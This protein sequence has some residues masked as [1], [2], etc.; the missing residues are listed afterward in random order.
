MVWTGVSLHHK[1]YIVFIN[2]NFTTAN[3]QHKVLHTEVIPLLKTHSGM[4]MLH[5]GAPAHCA[6]TTTAYLN[7]NN[8]NSVDIP[9]NSPD[10][11]IFENIW[12]EINRRERRTGAIPT[13]LNQLRA[14]ILF[15]W[16]DLP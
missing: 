12:D 8:V 15:E 6:R 9:T 11:N 10:L 16:N 7:A 2:G 1:T 13:T 4:Q 5:D 14:N 3:Y